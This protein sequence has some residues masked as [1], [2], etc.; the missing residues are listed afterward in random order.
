MR[1]SLA[2]IVFLVALA[3]GI[4]AT[5]DR[6]GD[7]SVTCRADTEG[8]SIHGYLDYRFTITNHSIAKSHEVSIEVPKNRSRYGA[9]RKLSRTA[10]VSPAS[11]VSIP[12]FRPALDMYG[13][14]VHV[15]VDG[16]N[17]EGSISLPYVEHPYSHYGNMRCLLLA[18]SLNRDALLDRLRQLNLIPPPDKDNTLTVT[19]AET[20][21]DAWSENWLSYSRYE[22]VILTEHEVTRMP[23][24]VLSA[25]GGYMKCGGMVLV[26][27]VSEDGFDAPESWT[28]LSPELREGLAAY[29]AGFGS[30]LAVSTPAPELLDR[31][32]LAF[33]NGLWDRTC[34]PFGKIKDP[35]EA[36]KMFPIVSDMGTKTGGL[37]L[38]MLAFVI[39]VGPVNL[40]VLAKMNKKIWLLWTVPGIS[41]LTCASIFM[42]SMYSEGLDS[43]IRTTGLTI[44]DEV[45][46]EAATI[47]LTAIYCR[48]T[49]ADGLRFSDRT[50]LTP[51]IPHWE[52]TSGRSLDW[53][54]GQHLESGWVTSRIPA[55]FMVR[56]HERRRER[57]Q[58]DF[59]EPDRPSVVN[60]LGA[61]IK[62]LS[63]ADS[64]GRIFTGK[65]IP[66]G[67]A[68]R[69]SPK[70]AS[71]GK[72][73]AT[74]IDNQYNYFPV[75]LTRD[76]HSRFADILAPNT[77]VALLDGCPF[78]ENGL[79]DA[80]NLNLSCVVVGIM[81]NQR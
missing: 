7:I 16:R 5:A 3:T 41:V 20:D 65:N 21:V 61:P 64:E 76:S 71:A 8:Q 2:A 79:K 28:R 35:L 48:L 44:L 23:E 66:A 55:H 58:T 1:K 47:G 73:P 12:V 56:K 22:G 11:V 59:A 77:Y 10:I 46:H 74:T 68:A 52:D 19:R 32:Q 34:R 50:E 18:R 4:D 54:A 62:K 27:G 36:N 37:L 69:L 42:Y 33:I 13:R 15:R 72:W 75:S 43:D 24:R 30:C 80:D 14:Q 31:S 39:V 25:L 29:P 17:W 67:A 26:T 9:I 45:S 81:G 78:I 38:G 49:P 63:L 70:N 51:M 57:L 40:I 60:G 53:T 6:D